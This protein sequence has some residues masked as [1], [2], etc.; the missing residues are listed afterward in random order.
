[1]ATDVVVK[2]PGGAT[3]QTC[4]EHGCPVIAALGWRGGNKPFWGTDIPEA[5]DNGFYRSENGEP[6]TFTK[7]DD[8]YAVDVN[9]SIGMLPQ[10]RIG[11]V[12]MGN[13]LGPDQDHN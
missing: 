13:A 5:E 2:A 1:M 3:D 9:S 11:R 4:S 7:L 12:E 6:G 10:A 8:I